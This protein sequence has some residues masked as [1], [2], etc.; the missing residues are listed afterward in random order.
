MNKNFIVN[1]LRI[2]IIGAFI[3]GILLYGY[4]LPSA[5][6]YILNMAPEF[7]NCYYPWIIFLYL[8]GIPC[9]MVLY[10]GWKIVKTI[11]DENVFSFENS[12]RLG[13][14]SKLAV[15]DSAYLMAGNIIFFFMGMNHPSMFLL[16]T[17]IVFMGIAFFTVCKGL[18][19]LT[20]RAA[21]LQEQSDFTI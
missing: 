21:E 2:T 15:I 16:F 14:I 4:G 6:R 10:I 11:A 20:Y 3:C 12:K 8:T 19:M 7:G 5:G 9:F 17:A 13:T 1:G 18:A